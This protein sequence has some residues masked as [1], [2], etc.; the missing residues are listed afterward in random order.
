M[1]EA[2][3]HDLRQTHASHAVMNGKSLHASRRLLG[4]RRTSTTNRYVQFGDTTLSEAAERV[5]LVIQR[6]LHPLS[7]S[8]AKRKL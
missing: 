3:P 4:H 5:A 7:H 6:K 8:V 1:A 2:R